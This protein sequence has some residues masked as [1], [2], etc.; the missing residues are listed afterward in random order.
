M[1]I[2]LSYQLQSIWTN[3][4]YLKFIKCVYWYL[5][6]A[7]TWP[8]LGGSG[9]NAVLCKTCSELLFVLEQSR[10]DNSS[11]GLNWEQLVQF[12]YGPT[13]A[14]KCSYLLLHILQP[15]YIM[16]T[17]NVILLLCW[18]GRAIEM[19]NTSAIS[20]YYIKVH[21]DNLI[22]YGF[23]NISRYGWKYCQW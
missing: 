7:L 4:Y 10:V 3:K 22:H 21:L 23:F 16:K 15:S 5:R 2:S 8:P 12:A 18:W 11:H 20:S 6:H 17:R 19:S 1:W 13:C 9:P 14:L